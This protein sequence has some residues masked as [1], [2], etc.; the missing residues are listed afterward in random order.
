MAKNDGITI[1]ELKEPRKRYVVRQKICEG[2]IGAFGVVLLLIA[3]ISIMFFHQFL[4]RVLNMSVEN[5]FFAHTHSILNDIIQ[6]KKNDFKLSQN[7]LKISQ[8]LIVE[9]IQRKNFNYESLTSC[10]K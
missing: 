3:I 7:E 9:L 6:V 1:Q 10:A 2:L 5:I 8:G 4:T